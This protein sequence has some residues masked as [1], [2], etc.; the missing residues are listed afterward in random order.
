MGSLKTTFRPQEIVAQSYPIVDTEDGPKIYAFGHYWPPQNDIALHLNAYRIGLSKEEGGM[1]KARH[2]MEAHNL[3]WP[4][5]KRTMNEWMLKRFKTFCEPWKVITLAGGSGIAKSADAAAYA[6]EWWWALPE[7]RAVLVCSTTIQALTKRIWS[8]ISELFY[9]AKGN[10]PGIPR[11]APTPRILFN[12]RDEKHGIHGIALKEGDSAK[13]LQDIIGIHPKQGLLVICD[14]MTDVNPGIEDAIVNWDSAGIEF[15]LI[16]I[17]N[18]KSKLDP[19][20]RMSKP[21]RGWGTVNPDTSE[22]WETELG[23][24]LYFDCYKSPAIHSPDKERLTFL[25][26]SKKI[27]HEENRLGKDSPKF[28]RFIRG[29]WPPEDLTKTVLNL[30]TIEKHRAQQTAVWNGNWQITLAS[31]DPAFT[32]EGDECILRFATM[33]VMENGRIG[34]DFGGPQNIKALELDSRSKEPI[35]Y[36]IVKQIKKECMARGVE[37]HHFGIDTWGFGTGAGDILEREWSPEINRVIGI[38]TASDSYIDNDA[39]ERAKDVYVDKNTEM[40]FAMRTFVQTDQIRGLDDTTCEELCS[41]EYL[42]RGRKL[43]LETKKEYKSRM[44]REDSPTGSPDKAD[45]AVIIIEVAKRALGFIPNQRE[46]LSSEKTEWEKRWETVIGYRSG[47]EKTQ[48]Q[49]DELWEDGEGI[50]ES[51]LFGESEF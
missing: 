26:G 34:L 42:W 16:G 3:I 32:S 43:K 41:R 15:Q 44:G 31:C 8:Y 45:A 29:F 38:G 2:F 24:C 1:G 36:Q 4:D 33:G 27:K 46:M 9:S 23:C 21:K 40:W 17:G 11:S 5:R 10:M 18:S 39:G 22:I 48:A 7:E 25:I 47:G 49:H 20:G 50:L 19:H 30:S 12:Q 51:E 14:E 35:N 28:W 6:L 13:V 37:P